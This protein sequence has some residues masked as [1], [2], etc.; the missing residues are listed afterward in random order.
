M[1]KIC[2]AI[3]GPQSSGKGTTARLLAGK[4]GYLYLD[5]GALYR[6]M[7][8]FFDS[9]GISPEEAEEKH[10]EDID[11]LGF[12]N[13]KTHLNGEDVEDIIRGPHINS[14]VHTYAKIPFVRKYVKSK[15]G[16]FVSQS[17]V[18]MEGRDIGT[19]IMPNAE[20][21]VYLDANVE[22]R[23]KR[24]YEQYKSQGEDIT[25]EQILQDVKE[26]DHLDMTRDESPLKVADD[27]VIVD[28]TDMSIE[29]QVEYIYELAQ[30]IIN[31]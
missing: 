26:R 12:S 3:D 27:A 25:Y 2:I 23:A 29:G 21:K 11:D 24:R 19:V 18:V 10:L 17:G 31:S 7:A 30:K 4:L 6:A 22:V 15:M 16:L 20:L 28:T 9:R 13:M 8:H 14:I 1:L 5:S